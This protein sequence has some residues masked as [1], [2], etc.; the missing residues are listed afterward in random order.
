LPG[1][2]G[3]TLD[4]LPTI[5]VPGLSSQG[6]VTF[7]GSLRIGT[8]TVPVTSLDDTA[9]WTE[10]GGSGLQ[11]L[12]REND[13]IPGVSGA[14][15]GSFAFGSYAVAT[16][17]ASTGE[18][19]F[20]IKMKGTSSD[21]AILRSSLSSG[22][23]TI[24]I[25]ARE[26]AA[27]PGT[28]GVFGG[29]NSSLGAAARMDATGNLVFEAQ[30]KPS[31]KFGIWYQ[32][33]GGSVAK[34]VAAGDTAPGTSSATFGSFDMPSMGSGGTIA[35]R[36]TL[37]KDGDNASN[38]K[39]DGIWR[40]TGTG[41]YSCILR[42]GDPA[43]PGMVAGSKVGNP[44]NGW[45]NL[46]NHGA[47]RGWVDT[48]GDGISSYP[49]DTFGIYT[50]IGGT[51]RLLISSGDAAPGIAGASLFLIDHPI[52]SGHTAGSEYVAFL[53]TVT[54]GGVTAGA[55]DKGVWRSANGAAPALVLRTGDLMTTSQGSK[56]VF[57]IDIPGSSQ[58]VRIWEQSVMDD[59]GRILLVITYT[60]GSTAQVIA[61]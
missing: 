31:N 60:D 21:S 13:P 22:S 41:A 11:L 30:I 15:L 17:G 27:A 4:A 48:A 49:A 44:W 20:A 32:P 39:N 19:A 14:F 5:P 47:W 58:D 50:D 28:S 57:D 55:N 37:N 51:M 26:K 8:G 25:V 40:G 59:T 42:R 9:M 23:A 18:A 7:L 2:A 35:F 56:T 45:L 6:L 12:M 52:V 54:G 10:A 43:L 1:A 34:V 46:A 53:S 16:T 61:P 36:G 3:A 24:S 38:A 33:I 29:L